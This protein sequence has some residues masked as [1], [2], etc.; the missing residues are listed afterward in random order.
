MPRSAR[1]RWTLIIVPPGLTSPTRHV[2]IASRTFA[3]FGLLV[4]ACVVASGVWAAAGANAASMAADRLA[5]AQR[6]VMALRDTVQSMRTVAYVEQAR[7]RPPVDMI[8]PVLGEITSR[9]SRSR[10]HPILQIFRGHTGVD[11]GAPVGTRIVAP[12]AGTVRSVGWRLGYGLTVELAHNGNIVTRY[13]HCRTAFVHTGDRVA[14]GDTIAAVGTSGLS[15]GPHLHFEVIVRGTAVD[16]IKFIA[17]T[18]APAPALAD[19][20]PAGEDR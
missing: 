10:F 6:V 13:A 11:L 16:P 2:G 20:V 19:H 17:S 1:R 18:R 7:L 5:E 4:I 3:T 14:M 9:F 12:A 15:T 8:M